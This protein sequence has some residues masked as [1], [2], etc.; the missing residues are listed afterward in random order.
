MISRLDFLFPCGV[1]DPSSPQYQR[2]IAEI[3]R[4]GRWFE[5][6][7]LIVALLCMIPV[8]LFVGGAVWELIRRNRVSAEV[9][10]GLVFLVFGCVAFAICHYHEKPRR[11]YRLTREEYSKYKVV[12]A[13]VT[14][15]GMVTQQRPSYDRYRRLRWKS[16][17]PLAREGWSPRC[18]VSSKPLLGKAVESPEVRLNDVVYVGLDPSGRLPP[19]FLG[20]KSAAR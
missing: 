5:R 8:V 7:F 18:F 3:G 10:I 15:L 9:F 2:M 17:P 14:K 4:D 11:P 20:V 13:R 19:L 1:P 12:E 6:F 16:E